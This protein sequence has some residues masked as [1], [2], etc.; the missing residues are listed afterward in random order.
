[1]AFSSA[2]PITYPEHPVFLVTIL[3][4]VLQ[5]QAVHLTM[6]ILCGYLE[7]VECAGLWYLHLCT[8]RCFMKTAMS[9]A[10]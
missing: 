5:K 8:H 4:V 9:L 6:D 3:D 10:T 2:K 7:A 1:M